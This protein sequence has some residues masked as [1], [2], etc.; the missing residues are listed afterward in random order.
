MELLRTEYPDRDAAGARHRGRPRP[1]ST[2]RSTPRCTASTGRPWRPRSDSRAGHLPAERVPGDEGHLGHLPEQHRARG[3]PRLLPLPRRQPQGGGRTDHHPGLQRL[4]HHPGDGRDRTRRCWR[5]SGWPSRA[6]PVALALALLLPAAALAQAPTTAEEEIETCLG[7][8][9]DAS[10]TVDLPSGETVSLGVDKAAFARSVHGKVLKCTDCHPAMAEIPHPEGRWKTKAEF[11]ATLRESCR[12]CHFDTYRQTLDG[13]HHALAARGDARAPSCADCHGSHEISPPERAALAHLPDLLPPATRDLGHLRE[14]RARQGPRGG[15]ERRRA[16]VHG[17]PPLPRHRRPP[18]GAWR[19]K[20]PAALREVPH[21]QDA[22]GEVRAVHERRARPTSRT[23]TA[24]RPACA[25]ATG[26]R[27]GRSPRCASTAT[28]STTSPGSKDP[29]SPR[30]QG[31]PRPDL[32]EVPPRR[33]RELPRGLALPLRAELL[34]GAPG[35]LVKLFYSVLI[36]FMIG[37]LVLQIVLHLWRVVV[38]R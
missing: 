6:L 21:R 35:L 24:W 26:A 4:P 12:T 17:L 27:A 8:H 16:G 10:A 5:T 33:L 18:H 37:G 36:P 31:E 23:S 11:R 29:G 2:A 1:T 34:E 3:L 7:C 19:L 30:T 13:V 20:T 14:E 28:A 32:P 22:D 9:E 25:R 15:A 38:N